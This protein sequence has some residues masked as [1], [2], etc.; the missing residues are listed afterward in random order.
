MEDRIPSSLTSTQRGAQAIV[1]LAGALTILELLLLCRGEE[2]WIP[3]LTALPPVIGW[4]VMVGPLVRGDWRRS[5]IVALGAIGIHTAIGIF[6]GLALGILSWGVIVVALVV[7]AALFGLTAVAAF[8]VLVAAAVLGGRRDHEAGDA[9]LG[10]GGAWLAG[11][12]LLTLLGLES[13]HVSVLEPAGIVTMLGLAAGV[14]ALATYA[15]RAI[16]RRRWCARA[17]RGELRG[18]RVRETATVEE[19][20]MLP[21]VFGSSRENTGVL[22][23]LEMGGVLYRSGLIASPVAAI[24]LQP[25]L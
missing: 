18:W 17:L 16:A 12:Q 5:A 2:L 14:V 20:A 7:V 15:A 25:E 1:G 10:W 23:R 4:S 6:V 13:S 24:R 19:L 3:L 11:L 21:P 9:M 8:P 22:E